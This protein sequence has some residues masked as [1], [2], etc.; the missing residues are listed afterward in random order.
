MQNLQTV[1]TLIALMIIVV[2]VFILVSIAIPQYQHYTARNQIS[3]ALTLSSAVNVAVVEYL[4]TNGFF[5]STNEEAGLTTTNTIKDK[6]VSQVKISTNGVITVTF[7]A[8]AQ[9]LI[10]TG[11]MALTP[12]TNVDSI[13]WICSSGNVLVDIT[14]YL[15]SICK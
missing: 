9:S 15:P 14:D 5:P 8:A 13:S 3:E 1:F 11:V 2:I 12:T 10:T 7:S 4:D 6:Y